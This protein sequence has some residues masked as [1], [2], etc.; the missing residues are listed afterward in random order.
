MQGKA[1][2]REQLRRRW[3]WGGR[4]PACDRLPS[5]ARTVFGSSAACWPLRAAGSHCAALPPGSLG[6][7]SWGD[8]PLVGVVSRLTKQKGEVAR[9]E[10]PFQSAGAEVRYSKTAGCCR[11]AVVRHCSAAHC[12]Q[13]VVTAALWLHTSNLPQLCCAV[14]HCNLKQFCVPYCCIAAARHCGLAMH[15]NTAAEH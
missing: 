7:T 14:Q 4:A 10:R 2:A 1:A 12:G 8:K 6:L 15:V 3:D 11:G 5:T 13:M 9:W